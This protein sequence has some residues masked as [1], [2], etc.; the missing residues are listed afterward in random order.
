LW[1]RSW[2]YTTEKLCVCFVDLAGV[3]FRNRY[4]YKHQK[5]CLYRK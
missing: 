3:S 1:F 5:A 2:F 4:T